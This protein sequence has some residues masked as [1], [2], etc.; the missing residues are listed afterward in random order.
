MSGQSSIIVASG[1]CRKL[2]YDLGGVIAKIVIVVRAAAHE[3]L[4]PRAILLVQSKMYKPYVNL[5]TYIFG[6]TSS[7]A[8]VAD[9]SEVLSW[10]Y[11][12]DDA[13]LC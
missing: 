7:T 9:I 2:H 11:C 3:M 12:L 4:A 1:V 5:T 10:T 8:P 13:M 6:R